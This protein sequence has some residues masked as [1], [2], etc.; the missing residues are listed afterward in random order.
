MRWHTA[1]SYLKWTEKHSNAES[2]NEY[3]VQGKKL[4]K[5]D[6]EK[7]LY[8]KM[9]HVAFSKFVTQYGHSDLDWSIL[10]TLFVRNWK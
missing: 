9:T 7:Q 3:Y 4:I 6:N 1:N 8:S 5:P 2:N 10:T